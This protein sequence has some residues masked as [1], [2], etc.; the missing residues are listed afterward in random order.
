MDNNYLIEVLNDLLEVCIISEEKLRQASYYINS[1]ELQRLF[2]EESYQ[3]GL[4]VSELQAEVAHLDGTP[5][6][7]GTIAGSLPDNWLNIR[8]EFQGSDENIL[9]R[10]EE[11]E[12]LVS[13][14]FKRILQLP[15]PS[16]LRSVLEQKSAQ[17]NSALARIQAFRDRQLPRYKTA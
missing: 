2:N 11:S 16:Y 10:V 1:R 14:L 9:S 6:S 15:L 7:Q 4:L 13:S 3:R 8:T 5:V 17:I 12:N